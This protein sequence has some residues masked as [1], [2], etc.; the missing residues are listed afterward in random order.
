MRGRAKWEVPRSPIIKAAALK[1]DQ[2][3][4]RTGIKRRGQWGEKFV[5]VGP[6]REERGGCDQI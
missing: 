1:R 6:R 5:R 2:D 3:D 4:D